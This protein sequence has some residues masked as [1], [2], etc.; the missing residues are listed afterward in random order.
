MKKYGGTTRLELESYILGALIKK[1]GK[2]P[3]QALTYFNQLNHQDFTGDNMKLFALMKKLFDKGEKGKRKVLSAAIGND[4]TLIAALKD[5][6]NPYSC[7]LETWV[8]TLKNYSGIDQYLECAEKAMV[9]ANSNFRDPKAR[10]EEIKE[11]MEPPAITGAILE[12][13]TA[14]D[15]MRDYV[16]RQIKGEVAIPEKTGF[17]NLDALLENN[18]NGIP[19]GSILAILGA[20]KNGKSALASSIFLNRCEK[21]TLSVLFS[22]EISSRDVFINML[23]QHC[24][25]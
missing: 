23:A 16:E 24:G 20:T 2:E 8:P 11:A 6:N 14:T 4:E 25:I 19:S 13:K 5:A 15:L 18:S 12:G 17:P 10:L 3:E 7:Y 22:L 21:D 1:W 9:F